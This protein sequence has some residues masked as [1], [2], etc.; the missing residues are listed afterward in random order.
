MMAAVLFVIVLIG[1]TCHCKEME[2]V[3]I[4]VAV[5]YEMMEVVK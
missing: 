5:F 4:A 1:V 3:A 2:C